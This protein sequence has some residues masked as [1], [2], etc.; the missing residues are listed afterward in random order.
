MVCV[1]QASLGLYHSKKNLFS[2]GT[3]RGS[4]V[5]RWEG[6][7]RVE[8]PFC[9]AA[10][11]GLAAPIRFMVTA[12]TSRFKLYS[13][14][15]MH[16]RTSNPTRSLSAGQQARPVFKSVLNLQTTEL[17]HG[18]RFTSQE[19]KVTPRTGCAPPCSR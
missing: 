16:T 9:D 17:G 2:Q 14:R 10:Q 18:P 13:S 6:E 15:F 5:R 11:P 7:P 8:R 12:F 4:L 19:G 1:A 3:E